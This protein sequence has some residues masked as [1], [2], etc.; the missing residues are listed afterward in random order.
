MSDEEKKAWD[1]FKAASRLR[2]GHLK[3]GIKVSKEKHQ[4]NDGASIVLTFLIHKLTID[5][6]LEEFRKKYPNIPKY[7][8]ALH[9]EIDLDIYLAVEAWMFQDAMETFDKFKELKSSSI[10]KPEAVLNF[11]Q[12]YAENFNRDATVFYSSKMAP[13][14]A[15]YV[16]KK[17]N[18]M[19]MAAHIG[20]L[21]PGAHKML[22]DAIEDGEE[23]SHLSEKIKNLEAQDKGDA[24]K[25]VY[26]NVLT[27]LFGLMA[28]HHLNVLNLVVRI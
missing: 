10:Q 2:L 21:P 13:I 14:V 7:A 12:S 15:A 25:L 9:A 17:G 5:E 19:L 26:K 11:L 18:V 20:I 23:R 4:I 6:T 16:A 22:I 1:G 27:H 28:N 3:A 8:R 24:Y